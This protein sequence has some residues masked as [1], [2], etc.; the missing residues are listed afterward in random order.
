MPV[1]VDSSVAQLRA[2]ITSAFAQAPHPGDAALVTG[3]VSYDPEYRAV[4]QAFGG[5]HWCE[6]SRAFI[7]EHR[8]ALPLLGPAAFRFFLPAYLLAC[9]EGEADLDTAPLSV[10]SSLTPPEP[11]DVDSFRAFSERA[12]AFTVAETRAIA[13]YLKH[14]RDRETESSPEN[15]ATRTLDY[16]RSARGA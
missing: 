8:D 7:R 16:W 1:T 14:A 15:G 6:L 13:A 3:D 11:D 2:T 9:V 5:K 12:A 10:I 4:A